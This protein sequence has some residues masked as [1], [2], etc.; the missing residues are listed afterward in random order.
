MD[1]AIID[2]YSTDEVLEILL[3][4]IRSLERRVRKLEDAEELGQ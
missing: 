2:E 4:R 3:E 1:R